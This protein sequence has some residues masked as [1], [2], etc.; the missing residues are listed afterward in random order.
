M[1]VYIVILESTVKKRC[2]MCGEEQYEV[3][4]TV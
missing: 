3:S 1:S 2:E 4:V